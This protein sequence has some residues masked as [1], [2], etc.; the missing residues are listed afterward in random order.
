MAM[1]IG[2]P[3]KCAYDGAKSGGAVGAMKVTTLPNLHSDVF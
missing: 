1:M 3:V 2:A